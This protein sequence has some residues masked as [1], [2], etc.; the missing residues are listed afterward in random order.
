MYPAMK[1]GIDWLLGEMDQDR[2]LFPEGY[3][4]MEVYGLNAELIDVAAYTQQALEAA[5]RIAAVV[6]DEDAAGRYRKLASELKDRINQRFWIEQDGTY[7]DFYGS[8]SQAISAAAG[9]GKQIGLKGMDN[10]TATDRDLIAHYERLKAK[11]SA[12]PAGDRGWITN[13]NWVIA[14]PLETGIAP[15]DRA[16]RLL[17]KIRHEH[18]GEY[19]PYLSAVERQAMMTIST[20]VQAVAEANYGR[21]DVAMSYVDRI[22]QTFNRVTPGSMSEMMPDHG[23]FVIA[24]TSYGIVVPLMEHVFGVRP[25]AANRTVVFEPHLPAG[26]EDISVE[27]LPIGANVISF[28][29]TRSEQGVIYDIAAK[30]D[31]WSFILK[32]PT[33]SGTR[34]FLNDVPVN[35]SSSGIRMQGRQNRVRIVAK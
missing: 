2:D 32:L 24:W 35:L 18:S 12:M 17:D 3:G 20:G 1:H 7:A 22:A 25:D 13:E 6:S 9:A 30:Q 27:N 33:A 34:Y 11:F 19:G 29:R 15:Q 5:A 21:I 4:I 10:L 28:A 26:W 8:R 31:G 14:T 16:I 23:C